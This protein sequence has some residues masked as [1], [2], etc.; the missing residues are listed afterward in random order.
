[1]RRR[2]FMT[3]LGCA[4][5]AWPLAAR[6]QQSPGLRRVAVLL[7]YDESNPAAQD[8]LA[9]FRESLAR[10][11][12]KEGENIRFEYRWVAT[13]VNLMQRAA[14]DLVALQ[15]DL[16]F[17]PGS[18][19]ATAFL[20][21]QTHTIPIVFAN[22]VDPVGQGFVA[23][24]SRPGGNVTGLVNLE[25]SMASK[26]LELLKALVPSL[27]R[28][29]VPF[30]PATAP[31]ADFYLNYF[32]SAAPSFGVEVVAA[33]IADMAAFES[34]AAAQAREPNTGLIPMPSIFMSA[35][36]SEIAAILARYRLPALYPLRAYAEA[37]GLLS[38]GNDR[39]DNYRR[40]AT[41]VDRIL[42]GEKPSELPVEFP[43]KFELVI[44]RKA[45]KALGLTI[46]PSLLATADEVIE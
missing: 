27:A 20:V 23:S 14:Q 10:L 32:K 18:S 16:I 37:G 22:I 36:V 5:T 11:G 42:K 34:F 26:W 24:L 8:L 4:V 7:V 12:W 13:D 1:V 41:F 25:T 39:N 21:K 38:Y 15:P 29:V 40:A 33:P 6:A 3:F 17:V 30:N 31:Y 46:P 19:S 28:L 43:T 44:N 2:D 9:A 45:A 35:H